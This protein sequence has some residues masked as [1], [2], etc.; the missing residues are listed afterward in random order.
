[1]SRTQV[2]LWYNRFK[3]GRKDDNNDAYPGLPSTL[4]T[5]ENI[6]EMKEMILDNHRITIGEVVDDVGVSAHAKH[7]LRITFNYDPHLLKKV[8]HGC[9]SM[10]INQKLN[11]PNGSVQKTQDRK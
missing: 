4:R 9:M 5:D 2:Q 10:I 11:H 6:E 8:N 7:F 3:E 1:M